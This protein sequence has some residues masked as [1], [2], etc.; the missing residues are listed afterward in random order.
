MFVYG[1]LL[2]VCRYTGFRRTIVLD[3]QEL[4]ELLDLLRDGKLSWDQFSIA[5]KEVHKNR[6]GQPTLR[7][8]IPERPKDEDYFYANPQ[9]CTGPPRSSNIES[10]KS[11]I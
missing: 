11:D 7:K 4:V 2:F 10:R 8:V 3:R 1:F 5:V 6:M 9:E